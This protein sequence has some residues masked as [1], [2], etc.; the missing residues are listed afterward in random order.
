MTGLVLVAGV[1]AIAILAPVI[2][3]SDPALQHA[4]GLT[5]QGDPIPPGREFLLGADALGRDELSRL[6]YGARVSLVVGISA[7]MLAGVLGILLG[8]GA[9]LAQR[10]I[11]AAV[12]RLVD[13][14]ISFPLLLLSITI[15]AVTQPSTLT[16]SVIIGTSWGAYLARIVFL[17]A[18]SIREREFVLA[19]KTSGVR[20]SK[21]LRR[22]IIPHILPSVLVY[23][24]LGVATA[25]QVEAALSYIGIGIRPPSAS[26]GNM[27]ADGQSY[28]FSAPWLVA[29][30]GG[31]IVLTLI[32]FILLGDG[33]RD[34]L[35]PTL[36]RRGRILLGGLR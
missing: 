27:L 21:I 11:Q 26:W 1:L 15:L 12:M 13:A 22:H 8:G 19:A 30:P 17:Q 10:H 2:A 5:S 33:L 32:G 23:C 18:V 7:N 36:E 4:T 31:A 25:I 28:L 29:F 35:D 3:P 14:V 16:I 24:T 34:A 6:L 9:A 20:V